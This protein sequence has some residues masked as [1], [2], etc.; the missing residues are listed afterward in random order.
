MGQGRRVLGAD[1]AQAQ[2]RVDGVATF[3]EV[4]GKMQRDVWF[5][6][7]PKAS[8]LACAQRAIEIL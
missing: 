8:R 4:L 5:I 3:D 7:R 2:G 1:A 6:F